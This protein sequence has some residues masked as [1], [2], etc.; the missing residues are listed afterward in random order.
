MD[1]KY[2]NN[3]YLIPIKILIEKVY[4]S[5]DDNDGRLSINIQP[6]KEHWTYQ[7]LN[8]FD[9]FKDKF[10]VCYNEKLGVCV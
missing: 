6:T 10:L 3:F 7:Y 9:Y 8:T 2:K 5:T 4:I 1:E